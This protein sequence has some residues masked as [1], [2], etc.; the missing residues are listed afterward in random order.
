MVIQRVVGFEQIK[1]DYIL[2][3][4]DGVR[5][6]PNFVE[7]LF[8]ISINYRA[9]FVSPRISEPI[10]TASNSKIVAGGGMGEFANAQR[11]TLA[12]GCEPYLS[13]Q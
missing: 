3:I 2:A 8:D 12:D 1:S 5:F 9:D 7:R 6:K 11:Y 4:D 13:S 10:A